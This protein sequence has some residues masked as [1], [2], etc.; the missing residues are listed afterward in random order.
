MA[1]NL[2]VRAHPG[3]GRPRPLPLTHAVVLAF[4]A[5][6]SMAHGQTPTVLPEVRVV[7]VSYTHLTLPTKRIV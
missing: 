3:H 6:A 2:F 1:S 4:A 5:V 7:A